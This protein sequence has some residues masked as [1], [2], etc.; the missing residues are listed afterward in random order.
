MRFVI[1]NF[2][3]A[4]IGIQLLGCISRRVVFIQPNVAVRVGPNVKGLFYT[5]DATAKDWVLSTV[6]TVYPEGYYL[7]PPPKDATTLPVK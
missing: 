5:Y 7:L 6:P 4:S 3:I 2:L 1:Q